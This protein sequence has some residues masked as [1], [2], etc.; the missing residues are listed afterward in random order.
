L[1]VRCRPRSSVIKPLT[2]R[3][4]IV[5]VEVERSPPEPDAATERA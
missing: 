2:L 1:S 4:D 5:P 3:G